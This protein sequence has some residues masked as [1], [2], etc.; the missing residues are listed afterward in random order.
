MSDEFPL[1]RPSAA[2]TIARARA[3]RKRARPA[4]C[5]GSDSLGSGSSA[6][7]GAAASAGSRSSTR[8]TTRIETAARCATA[9]PLATV[10][11][12]ELEQRRPIA[13]DV[14]DHDRLVVQAELL[15]GD[16]L[17][18]LVER[19][20]AARQHREG[21]GHLEHA[22]LALVHAVDD[23]ELAEPGMADLAVVEMAGM[24]PVTRPPAASAASATSPIS[25]TRPPP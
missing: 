12:I 3:W 24:M 16:D 25:P 10:C 21:I 7:C 20:E 11:S 22:A 8:G 23:D 19:A 17:E 2:R 1:E 14:D 9:K 13:G 5:R 4:Q 18:R 6:G 15:P